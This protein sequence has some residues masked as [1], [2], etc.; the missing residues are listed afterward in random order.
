MANFLQDHNGNNSS[1]R[2]VF[3]G[4]NIIAVVMAFIS[5]FSESEKRAIMARDFAIVFLG[6]SMGGKVTQLA[7]EAKI[8]YQRNEP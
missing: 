1:M 5:V 2:L 4:L 6:G 3:V 8:D 7:Q